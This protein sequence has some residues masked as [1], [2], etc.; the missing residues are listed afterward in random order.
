MFGD[1]SYAHPMDST[2][3]PK[4][5][6]YW[7]S[8]IRGS[9]II[10]VDVLREAGRPPHLPALTSAEPHW[11]LQLQIGITIWHVNGASSA[12]SWLVFQEELSFEGEHIHECAKLWGSQID[13][14]WHLGQPFIK[15]R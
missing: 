8:D 15:H 2:L 10:F 3:C 13:L 14:R 12:F 7:H 11:L 4:P 5:P 9:I 6:L 1:K